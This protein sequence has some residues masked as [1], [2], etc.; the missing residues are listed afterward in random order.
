MQVSYN[1]SMM[2]GYMYMDFVAHILKNNLQDYDCVT[3]QQRNETL[4]TIQFNDY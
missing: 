4:Q 3:I 1:V 2:V